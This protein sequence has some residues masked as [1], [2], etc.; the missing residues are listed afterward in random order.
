MHGPYPT[1]NVFGGDRPPGPP[2]SPPMIIGHEYIS[3]RHPRPLHHK[4]WGFLIPKFPGLTPMLDTNDYSR[5]NGYYSN[6]EPY[7]DLHERKSDVV[8]L[9]SV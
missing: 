5:K 7:S 4:I 2:K 6:D 3:W 1:S 8:T 9:V